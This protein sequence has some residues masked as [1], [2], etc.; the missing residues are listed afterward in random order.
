[1]Q[2]VINRPGIR[3]RFER[4]LIA[5]LQRLPAHAGRYPKGF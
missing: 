4:D 1:L 2:V 3:R 5:G